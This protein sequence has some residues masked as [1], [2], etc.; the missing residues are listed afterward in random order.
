MAWGEL[1]AALQLADSLVALLQRP[2]PFPRPPAPSHLLGRG[3]ELKS[4]RPAKEF[5]PA[6][7][8]AAARGCAHPAAGMR[9]RS[10]RRACTKPAQRRCADRTPTAM[11]SSMRTLRIALVSPVLLGCRL[12]ALLDRPTGLTR[13]ESACPSGAAGGRAELDPTGGAPGRLFG[14]QGSIRA[15]GPGFEGREPFQVFGPAWKSHLRPP[16]VGEET[17][18]VQGLQAAQRPITYSGETRILLDRSSG[19]PSRPTVQS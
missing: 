8:S 11:S 17:A 13:R 14:E 18:L 15:A 16:I 10:G 4:G 5:G 12:G 9:E 3:C 7:V 1:R 19:R 6:R 2:R